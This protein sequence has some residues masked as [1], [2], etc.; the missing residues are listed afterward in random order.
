MDMIGRDRLASIG[1]DSTGST[2]LGRE[3][4]QA[5]VATVL[6]VTDPCHHLSN[7][8]KDIWEIIHF[9]DMRFNYNG[10]IHAY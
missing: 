5:E 6:I 8:I 10:I 4:A 1:S 2:K 9:E 3:L 7:T